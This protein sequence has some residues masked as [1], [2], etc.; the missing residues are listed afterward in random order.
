MSNSIAIEEREKLS[1]ILWSS[2]RSDEGGK[3]K[4]KTR[5]DTRLQI[6]MRGK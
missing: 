1:Y 6:F 5:W 3:G 4:I 2:C